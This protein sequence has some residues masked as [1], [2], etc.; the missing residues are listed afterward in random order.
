MVNWDSTHFWKDR[1][2]FA[3]QKKRYPQAGGA[4]DVFATCAAPLPQPSQGPLGRRLCWQSAN[5]SSSDV[6]SEGISSDPMP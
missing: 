1:E 5:S 6:L 2:R 4:P 3:N